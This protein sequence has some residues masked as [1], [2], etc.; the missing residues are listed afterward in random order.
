M[1][2]LSLFIIMEKKYG[3]KACWKYFDIKVLTKLN[4]AN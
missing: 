4:S 1:S 3:I 2:Y